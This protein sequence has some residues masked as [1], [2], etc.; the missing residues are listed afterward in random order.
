M[1]SDEAAASSS[2]Q[3]ASSSPVKDDIS[4]GWV[5]PIDR[6]GGK[7]EKEQARGQQAPEAAAVE[8][9]RALVIDSGAIIKHSAFSTLHN[10]AESYYTVPSVLDEIRDAKARQHLD[11]LPFELISSGTNPRG[12]EG[13]VRL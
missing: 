1:A 10:A 6:N 4:G 2:Q 5:S 3:Q 7:E 9:Y 11:N 13:C 8:K 12:H